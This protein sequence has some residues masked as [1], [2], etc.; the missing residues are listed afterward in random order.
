MPILARACFDCHGPD[1]QESDLRLDVRQVAFAGGEL[2]GPA[3]V[4]GNAA[5]SPLV[6]FI[7]GAGVLE[8]PPSGAQLTPDEVAVISRWIDAGADWPGPADQPA[9][10]PL[11]SDHWSLQPLASIEPP[12]SKSLWIANGV[13]A[14]ILAK[15][16]DAGLTP[17]PPAD[18][19]T[20]IRRLYFDLLG[21]P[22]TPE[23]TAAFVADNRPHAYSE[24]V[25]RVLASPRYG[26][27]W[28][29]H[30]LDVARFAETNGFEMNQPRPNA[31]PYRDYVIAALNDDKPYDQFIVEQLAGDALGETVATG[32]LVA[33][34]WDQVK[35]P[36]VG[37]TLMQRQDELADMT[38]TTAT[39]MLGLTVGCAR[40]HNHK[41][42][43]ILQKDFYALEAVFAGVNHGETPW[44]KPARGAADDGRRPAVSPLQNEDRFAPVAARAVRFTVA[45]TNSGSEPCL[46]ELEVWSAASD[47]ADAINV[48]LAERGGRP[49]SSGNYPDQS[50]HRLANLNDGK[51]G[52]DWSWIAETHGA[53]W[54][55]V[56][57]AEAQVIDRV[58][59]GRDR[60]GGFTDRLPV[61]Y[62]IEVLDSDNHWHVV[63]TSAARRR[64]NDSGAM[65][66]AGTFAQPAE[67]TRRLH[68]GDPLSPKEA[69]APDALS[70]LG[71]LELPL[72]APE[73]Q[74]RLA[75]ARWIASGENPLTARVMVNRVWQ[76]HFGVGLVDTPSDFGANGTPPTHPELLDWL[77]RQFIDHGWSLKELHRLI[78]SSSAYRQANAP[79]DECL[80]VDAASRLLWRYPPRR[81]ESEAIH[82]AVLQIAG[83]LDLTMGGPGWSPFEPNDNYVRVYEP[84]T[85]FG[86]A[87]WRRMI[88]MNRVRMR[89]DAIFGAF[90]A[91]DGGQVCP[92][93]GA[94]I[95]AIQALNLFNSRFM[96]DQ[97]AH[98][99]ARLRQE[100]GDERLA[101]VDRAF[102]L[103]FNRAPDATELVA[104]Q[105]LIAT[106]GLPAFC[107]SVLNA[108]ELMFVP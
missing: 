48:A 64:Y 4:P 75:L 12:P 30:W 94:S 14:F 81:L 82:D 7:S 34:P 55:Q 42:D 20:L 38:N 73:Q 45:A 46:D 108:N 96:I 44:I 60:L 49:S 10:A 71:T 33:G 102:Q 58:V 107:R 39:A 88:Y 79:R 11:R 21:L 17:S 2:F 22:P 37:L 66:Y 52:N 41:F 106:H 98:F 95:T 78:A 27:R 56:D 84:K 32:F 16:H 86:P 74:R 63:A 101:Q 51:Y 62:A 61:D 43:P 19:R 65:V 26:E 5:G 72:D 80:A 76:H 15:L 67:P 87:E 70:V 29:Q 68:R 3:I 35:S 9:A 47:V 50:K 103:A 6:Q 92:K 53:G 24:L 69:V 54:A 36:D 57:F 13:D 90:D 23:E 85:E 8:M 93:R 105:Q 59:W 77:A 1:A 91:P 83:T 40:C 104:A 100:A 28:A 97:A 89:P 18:R 31:W 99:A 25:E